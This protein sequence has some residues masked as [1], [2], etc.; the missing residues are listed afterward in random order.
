M[1]IGHPIYMDYDPT[2]EPVYNQPNLRNQDTAA[3][4]STQ[5]D[6]KQGN[7]YQPTKFWDNRSGL[8]PYAI[9]MYMRYKH[10]APYLAN[11][12]FYPE[13]NRNQWFAPAEPVRSDVFNTA[14][15]RPFHSVVA[16]EAPYRGIYTGI[17]EQSEIP[18]YMKR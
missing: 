18:S 10:N 15:A 6:Y 13:S 2:S 7:P 11:R 4:S 12:I 3:A 9:S 1:A 17:Y 14:I 8:G 5:Y 16:G